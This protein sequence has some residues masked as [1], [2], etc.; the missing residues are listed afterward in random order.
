MAVQFHVAYSSEMMGVGVYAGGPYYC[1]QGQLSNAFTNC[2]YGIMLDVNKL[3]SL[4]KDFE[5]KYYIDHLA[6]LTKSR[7]YL[8]SG[9]KDSVVYPSVMKSSVTYYQ[10]FVDANNIKTDFTTPSE[11]CIP[12]DNY[13]NACG[14]KGSPYISNCNHDGAGLTL[15]HIYGDL[16]PRGEPKSSN[17]LTIDQSKFIP[18]G[19]TAKSIS[20]AKNAFVYVPTGCVDKQIACKIHISFHGCLQTTADIGDK[21]YS[22]AGF[23]GWAESNNIIV[24]YPQAVK[25]SFFAY[26]S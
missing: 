20:V 17:L 1:A 9:S 22:H 8:Y 13:G 21:Y 4:T 2:M 23:N 16:S 7:V 3:I 6:N 19:Y 18:S 5:K 14:F 26:K 25:S 24:L 10:A 11:H 12:T 15:K